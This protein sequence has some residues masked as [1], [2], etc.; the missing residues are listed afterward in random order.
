VNNL[1]E[2]YVFVKAFTKCGK[3]LGIRYCESFISAYKPSHQKIFYNAGLRP[4][5]YV[6]SWIYNR[7]K[8]SFE[9]CILF[10]LYEGKIDDNIQLIDEGY[11]LLDILSLDNVEDKGDFLEQNKLLG[12]FP[13]LYSF[14]EKISHV[15]NFPKTVKSTLLI[16]LLVYLSLV[17]GSVFVADIH[18]SFGYSI[19][20]HTISE[21]GTLY[22]SPVPFIFDFACVWGG[23]I[24]ILMYCYLSRRIEIRSQA[25]NFVHVL[26]KIAVI[27]GIIGSIGYM[28]V[29]ILSLDRASGIGHTIASVIAFGGFI[30]GLSSFGF[31]IF[32]YSSRMPR[33]I[34]LNA[35]VPVVI[36]VGN[37]IIPCALLEWI[38]LISILTSLS[39]F[40]FWLTFKN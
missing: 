6:P 32:K 34:G 1:E 37:C 11:I 10:N 39:P 31:I 8:Q 17:I 7:S 33:I 28:L 38:L 25:S 20:T 12:I 36:L 14:K 5:G 15:W 24:T 35:M 18:G 2:L 9:D 13:L 23:P 29:G 21:L 27:T 4:R 22:I 30:V 3:E 19:I 16:G 26:L 40:V